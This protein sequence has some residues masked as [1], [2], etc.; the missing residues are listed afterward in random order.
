MMKNIVV[1]LSVLLLFAGGCA[2]GPAVDSAPRSPDQ[3]ITDE[4]LRIIDDKEGI[5]GEDLQVE[6]RDGVVV[7]SGVQLEDAPVGELL[8]R[9]ARVRGVTE[10]VNRIRILRAPYPHAPSLSR[11]TPVQPSRILAACRRSSATMATAD[12][13]S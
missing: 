4:V 10:V 2:A 3:R 1:F 9:I 13:A 12:L 8:M 5:V 6:T 11:V 7:V